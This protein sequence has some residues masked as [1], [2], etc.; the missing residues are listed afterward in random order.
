MYHFEPENE[1]QTFKKL[2]I[3]SALTRPELPSGSVFLSLTSI[4]CLA[5]PFSCPVSAD[6]TEILPSAASA[7]GRRQLPPLHPGGDRVYT[8]GQSPRLRQRW[9]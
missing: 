9:L 6:N 4:S 2:L 7:G 3:V 5:D 8:G 1:H